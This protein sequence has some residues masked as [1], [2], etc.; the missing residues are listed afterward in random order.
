MDIRRAE[1]SEAEALSAIARASKA[2]WP[3]APEQIEAWHDDL[4]LSAELITA[5][6]TFVALVDGVVAGFHQ[7]LAGQDTWVL[8]HLW[9]LPSYMGKGMGRALLQQATDFARRHGAQYIGIDADPHAEAFY[10]ACG[11]Q[12]VE[13]KAAPIDGAPERA[14]PQMILRVKE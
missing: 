4:T 10:A 1:A 9:V 6:P 11:A 14:R 12:T 3:Y 13:R 7:L 2:H 5:H 8:E